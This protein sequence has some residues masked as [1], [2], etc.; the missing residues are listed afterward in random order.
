[1]IHPLAD[2]QSDSIG[3]DTTIWQFAIVLKNAV[4]GNNCN[5]NCHTFIENDV[6]IGNNVTIKS[7]V[8]LWDGIKIEDDV[9]VGPNVTFINDYTPR[10]KN[11]DKHFLQ[12]IIQK[13]ASIGAAATIMGGLTIG[14]YAMIGAGSMVTKNIPSFTL[15]YGFTAIQK[16]YVT[17]SGIILNMDLV[18][19]KTGEE[20]IIAENNEPKKKIKLHP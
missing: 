16:G 13:G 3:L 5:I 6:V 15:W 12:T 9:F 8:Y 11:H 2:V 18:D 20:Y 14:E 1:M 19:L 10:S 7:G 17:K 4:I